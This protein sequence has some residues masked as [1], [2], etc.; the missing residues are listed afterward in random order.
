MTRRL[1]TAN[2]IIVECRQIIVNQGVGVNHFD[3][4][5]GGH[6]GLDVAANGFA[7]GQAQYRTQTLAAGKH[8]I[9]AGRL[10]AL[11]RAEAP[12]LLFKFNIDSCSQCV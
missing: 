1:S 3:S 5:G 7:G 4:T 6:G 11:R 2:G 12:N 9:Q 10:H 8:T